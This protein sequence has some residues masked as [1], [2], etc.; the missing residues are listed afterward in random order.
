MEVGGHIVCELIMILIRSISPSISPSLLKSFCR[1]EWGREV[2]G[3]GGGGEAMLNS[4]HRV[5]V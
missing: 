1:E 5:M 4:L 2:P 3:R